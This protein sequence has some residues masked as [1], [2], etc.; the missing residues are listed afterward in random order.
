[1]YSYVWD[2]GNTSQ[3]MERRSNEPKTVLFVIQFFS[4]FISSRYCSYLGQFPVLSPKIKNKL[5]WQK[6]LILLWKK[7]FLK[8]KEIFLYAY[9]LLLYTINKTPLEKTGC[10]SNLYYLLTARTSSFLIYTISLQK[11]VRSPLV[12]YPSLYSICVTYRT[13]CY[14]IGHQVLPTQPWPREI[15]DFPRGGKY[16]NDVFLPTFLPYFPS[17]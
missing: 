2:P 9:F 12:T 4:V 11:S 16:S 15:G 13:S 7:S 3:L 14:F 5:P 1:M 8:K 17:V 6:Y 10:L